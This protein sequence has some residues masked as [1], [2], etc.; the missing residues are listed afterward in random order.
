MFNPLGFNRTDIAEYEYNGDSAV[1]VVDLTTGLKILSQIVTEDGIGKIRIIADEIPA[2]GYKVYEIR[3]GAEKVNDRKVTVNE[4]IIEN[5]FYGIKVSGNGSISSLIDK[6]H[7]NRELVRN[8]DGRS[9][10]DLGDGQG[11]IEIEQDGPLSSTLIIH[12]SAPLKHITRITLYHQIDRISI[13]NEITENFSSEGD[14]PPQWAFSFDIHSP[15][16]WHEEIGAVIRARLLDNGGHYSPVHARYDW[17]T[18]N[19]F[20]DINDSDRIWCN[21]IK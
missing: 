10:N 12:S 9:I 11:V 16:I 5:D 7:N 15:D 21:H 8:I 4:N 2:F 18:L 3:P 1:H 19:H 20:A 14:F 6:K 17:L 13:R